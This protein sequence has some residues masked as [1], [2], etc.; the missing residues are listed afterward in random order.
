MRQPGLDDRHRDKN[1]EISRKHGDTLIST[2]RQTYGQSFAPGFG[3]N[4]R[5][6]E[7]LDTLDE[8][9]LGQMVR[10][11]NNKPRQLSP[12]EKFYAHK[13]VNE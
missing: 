11:L 4:L 12:M 1:G 2:L 5:L 10:V 8:P 3:G 6:S 7:V 13:K 9:S